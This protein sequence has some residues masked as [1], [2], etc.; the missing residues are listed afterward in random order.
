MST[1][2]KCPSRKAGR[3]YRYPIYPIAHTVISS[4]LS[5]HRPRCYFSLLMKTSLC[6]PLFT[7][8]RR[9]PCSRKVRSSAGIQSRRSYP[10][11]GRGARARMIRQR[12]A[13]IAMRSIAHTHTHTP[14]HWR[15]LRN[16]APRIHIYMYIDE[17]I[18]I[19]FLGAASVEIFLSEKL[20]TPIRYGEE[21]LGRASVSVYI[22]ECTYTCR[23][24]DTRRDGFSVGS[25]RDTYIYICQ[26]SMRRVSF[27]ASHLPF[28]QSTKYGYDI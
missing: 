14:T 28:F 12:L 27:V 17:R 2:P 26:W 7:L 3:T 25:V 16:S 4:S 15:T 18:W 22:C 8:R 11:T 21:D 1:R 23:G 20:Y 13:E 19:W 9:R 10:L 6:V 5:R 24:A